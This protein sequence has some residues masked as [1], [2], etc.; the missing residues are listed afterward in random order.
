[1]RQVAAMA[2]K[3]IS[4]CIDSIGDKMVKAGV[5]TQGEHQKS[6]A[7]GAAA[8]GL[9]DQGGIAPKAVKLA[10]RDCGTDDSELRSIAVLGYN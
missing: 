7:S 4:P 3:W 9:L 8:V 6:S 2:V 10:Y 1:M 5:E